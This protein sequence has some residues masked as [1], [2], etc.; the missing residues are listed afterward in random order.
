M[1][2]YFILTCALV[3]HFTIIR[4]ILYTVAQIIGPQNVCF[5]LYNVNRPVKCEQ[6][7]PSSL[8]AR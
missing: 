3:L 4:I 2:R 6:C 5:G 8:L 1:L 7:D